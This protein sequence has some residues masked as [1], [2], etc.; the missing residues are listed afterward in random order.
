MAHMQWQEKYSVKVKEIDDQH[1][2]LFDM[3]NSLHD[4]MIERRGKVAMGGLLQELVVYA[5]THFKLEE[6]YMVKF[7]YLG[8]MGQQ[9]EH[10]RFTKKVLDFQKDFNEGKIIFSLEVMNFLRDWL[11]NHILVT[12]MK[13]SSF[14]NERGL[15]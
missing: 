1:R 12:D 10:G 3:I 4:A 7:N 13:Y 2:K 8:H 6:N 11:V 14:F 5:E 15:R 9:S